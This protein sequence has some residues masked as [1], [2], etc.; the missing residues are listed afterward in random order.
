MEQSQETISSL[1]P[2]IGRDCRLG[3]YGDAASKLNKCVLALDDFRKSPAGQKA[4]KTLIE[5]LNYSLETVL[6]MLKNKDW[7]AV[8][9]VIE[10]ELINIWREI[11]TY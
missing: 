11:A 2:E 8:A 6:M 3:D 9:D 1:L 10:Y 4:P 7:V 5:K